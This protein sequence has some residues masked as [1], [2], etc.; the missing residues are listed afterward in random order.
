[1]R[2]VL[3]L[4]HD[5]DIPAGYLGEV[6][7]AAGVPVVSLPLYA[8]A[9][10]PDGLDWSAVVSL[11]GRM[12]SY[13]ERSYPFLAAEKRFLAGAVAA[14]IPV[15]GICLG[16]QLLADALGGRVYR[17][18]RPEAGRLQLETTPAGRD[19]PV[20]SRMPRPVLAWH[21]DTFDLP[22]GAAVLARSDRF[23][24]AFRL[25]P[26]LG[27]Q[28]HPEVSPRILADWIDAG[29]RDELARAGVDA[30]ALLADLMADEEAVA[31]GSR[32]LFT[33]WLET[34]AV[35]VS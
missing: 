25:G 15:L 4:R 12:G 21:Q 29:G 28:A 34:V 16:C 27:I 13:E 31:A 7:A 11:G 24:H 19:D 33:G 6:L 14:D 20:V 2:P 22:P 10:V 5:H 9:M 35:P 3:V 17:A 1:M 23:P 8:G 26:A 30:V 18:E 32:E